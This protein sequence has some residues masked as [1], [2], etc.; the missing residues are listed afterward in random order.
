M[1]FVGSFL[2]GEEISKAAVMGDEFIRGLSE[3]IWCLD[4]RGIYVSY[5]FIG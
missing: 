2:G 3:L 1:Y 5:L 4:K